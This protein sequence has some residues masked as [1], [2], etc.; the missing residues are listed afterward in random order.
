MAHRVHPLQN[1]AKLILERAKGQKD[2]AERLVQLVMARVKRI[3]SNGRHK[4]A[5]NHWQVSI[6]GKKWLGEI[7]E[8]LCQKLLDAVHKLKEVA[9][10]TQT[11]VR[12]TSLAFRPT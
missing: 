1:E 10:Q 12:R 8:L 6:R 4:V 7:R 11:H 3:V 5:A 9:E 2:N